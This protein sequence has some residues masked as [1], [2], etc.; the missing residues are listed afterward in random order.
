[1]NH[2]CKSGDAGGKTRREGLLGR[3]PTT[4]RRGRAPP[5]RCHAEKSATQN[6]RR[7]PGLRLKPRE[8]LVK[9]HL[10]IGT[11]GMLPR[12][13]RSAQGE[14]MGRSDEYRRYAA[15]CLEMASV[16]HDPKARAALLLMAQ[17]WLRLASRG[18]STTHRK[19]PVR[20]T[21]VRAARES[22][23]PRPRWRACP[24]PEPCPPWSYGAAPS[25]RLAPDGGIPAQISGIPLLFPCRNNRP[26]NR[27]VPDAW[28]SCRRNPAA[29]SRLSVCDPWG[30]AKPPPSGQ[31]TIS[32]SGRVDAA[33]VR[34]YQ[35]NRASKVPSASDRI[36]LKS[37]S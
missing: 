32:H 22:L 7:L 5:R 37:L 2:L 19:N 21:R 27:A 3:G 17:V 10:V 18:S 20:A 33:E 8:N 29:A 28:R 35:F 34:P 11:A 25:W 6:P 23:L 12:C 36:S 4:G 30:K 15:E 13:G 14:P 9:A 1:E 26:L 16:I 31:G 24:R